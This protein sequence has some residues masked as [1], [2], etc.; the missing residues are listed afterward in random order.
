M[1]TDPESSNKKRKIGNTI[2]SSPAKH[3]C[4]TYNNYPDEHEKLFSSIV[5]K[6]IRYIY[7]EET[8]ENG[9]KHLQGYIEFKEKCRPKNLLSDKI[10]WEKCKNILAS[11]EYCHKTDTRTGGVF[12]FNVYIAKPIKIIEKLYDWQQKIVNNIQ[13]EADDRHIY[14]FYETTGNI[15]KSALVKYIC[16]RF[17]AVCVSGK[18]A[19]AKH[20]IVNYNEKK[21]HYP[22]IVIFDI[23]RSNLDYVSYEAMEKIKDGLFCA[24]KYESQMVIM[25][26]PHIL[27]FANEKP[28][29][30]K[31]SLDRWVIVNLSSPTTDFLYASA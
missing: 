5:P 1:P 19:D 2:Q 11:I 10:H 27:C 8:G 29:T 13:E 3:W 23:P 12:N 26:S 7:Q 30:D 15:G 31:M 22:E 18:S 28:Y 16:Q 24:T 21:G 14:W 20:I 4:F 25:N 6:I 17:E 9:T